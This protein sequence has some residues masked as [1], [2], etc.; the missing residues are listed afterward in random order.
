MN[1]IHKIVFIFIIKNL[2]SMRVTMEHTKILNKIN[3]ISEQK[4][5]KIYLLNTQM[6]ALSKKKFV[7]INSSTTIVISRLQFPPINGTRV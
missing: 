1:T 3:E 5:K 6:L 7:K 2:H 4:F